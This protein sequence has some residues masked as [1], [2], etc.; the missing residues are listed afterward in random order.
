METEAAGR[1]GDRG[2]TGRDGTDDVSR[3]RRQLAPSF[4]MHRRTEWSIVQ[5]NTLY[6]CA[7]L[8]RATLSR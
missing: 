7:L 5:A 6:A 1:A 2:R 8:L 4:L 3:R